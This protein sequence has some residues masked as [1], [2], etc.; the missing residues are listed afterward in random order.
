MDSKNNIENDTIK[1]KNIN[2]K[3]L[4]GLDIGGSLTKISIVTEKEEKQINDFLLS[5]KNYEQIEIDKY[6]LYLTNFPTINFENNISSLIN[7]L[8]K[9]IKIDKIE[10]TGG[11]AYKFYKFAKNTLNIEF[12]KHDELQSLKYGYQFMNVYH[13]FY[14]KD[15]NN[16][17][18]KLKSELKF[19]H[20]SAN[21]G[22]GVSILKVSSPFTYER[23]GG[24][25]M[26]GGTLIGLSKLIFGI[27][28]FD[29]ILELASKG[30]YENV[31]LTKNDLANESKDKDT[32]ENVSISSLGKIHEF[33][34]LGKKE[35]IKKEDIALSLLNMICSHIAQYSVLYAERY[36]IDT[37]YYFGTF[38]KKNSI[39]DNV[40]NKASKYWNKDIKVRFNYFGGYLG[41]IGT[42]IE[43]SNKPSK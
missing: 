9:I 34:R 37:I 28:D 38:T 15:N 25:L 17:N 3:I 43:I 10:A 35:E 12:I 16:K 31:D 27:D 13:S 36:N 18:F 40:L 33:I 19:P 21:I 26:G 32:T 22:S 39:V 14:E 6:Y 42:L 23:I 24:T 7:E 2:N 8:K 4:I 20:I 5:Q 41:A 11:G 1:I 29:E 30:K